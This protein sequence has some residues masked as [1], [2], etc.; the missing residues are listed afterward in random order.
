M[1][2]IQ[3]N[4]DD[5]PTLAGIWERSVKATH[6]FLSD[7]DFNEIKAAL[8]PAY[9]PNVSLYA[10]VD[11]RTFAGFIGLADSSIE[12]LFIDSNRRGMGY[13]SA[14]IDFAKQRGVTKVDVNEQNPDALKFYLSKGFRIIARSERD[15]R[16]RPYPILHLSL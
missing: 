1:K 16:G 9:F 6:K 4:K 14:L 5:Y 12:M 13:G 2:I 11:N 7:E 3:C 10:I 15:D 8:V